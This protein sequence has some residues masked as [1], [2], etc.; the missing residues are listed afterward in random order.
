MHRLAQ[1]WKIN[2]YFGHIWPSFIS[3][4]TPLHL[5]REEMEPRYSVQ[6]KSVSQCLFWP[7]IHL[8][9][10]QPTYLPTYLASYL[11]IYLF[12]CIPLSPYRSI[13]VNIIHV[14]SHHIIYVYILYQVYNR[15]IKAYAYVN[16]NSH[17]HI[18]VC[19]YLLFIM[20]HVYNVYII[21]IYANI[22][23]THKNAI[24]QWYL[25]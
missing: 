8:P 4:H 24:S 21:Y 6:E 15:K 20:I 22:I 16:T 9:T 13:Q 23:D 2:T 14:Y 12:L 5:Q 25:L 10:C 1:T 11:S 18:Y 7:P 19:M 3:N 17:T